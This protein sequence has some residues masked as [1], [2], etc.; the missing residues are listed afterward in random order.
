M[1]INRRTLREK[2]MQVLYAN[3]MTHDDIG[4]IINNVFEEII[5]DRDSMNFA[6]QLIEQVRTNLDE[7]DKLIISKT[8]NW[9]SQRL[10]L[11]DRLLLRMAITEFLY[12]P[13]IPPKVTINE[14][15]E[16]AKKF[17]TD[18]SSKF[19]NGIL[20][21]ILIDLN[22]SKTLNKSGRGLI[23]QSTKKQTE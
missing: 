8:N 22:N 15:M 21:A 1:A 17:S 10:A 16:I 13:D 6:R 4:P 20:D 2:V 5:M 9:E 12:F 7:I 23:S 11:I 18:Q 14:A 3:E 19:I